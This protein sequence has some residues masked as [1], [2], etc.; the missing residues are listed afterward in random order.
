MSEILSVDGLHVRYGHVHAV[1]D[2]SF[3]VQ[4]GGLMT[5]VGANGAGKTSILNAIAGLVRPAGGSITFKGVDV[6]RKPAHKMVADGLVQV[7]E[8]REVLESLSVAENL[9]LGAWHRRSSSTD[10]IERMYE[11][12]PV[13]AQRR[14]L[15]AGSLSGGEQQ[16][17]AI[18]RALVAEP[19]LL[20]MDEPSM[21]LAPRIVDEVFE[22][23]ASIQHSGT[24]VVLVEQNARRALATADYG[25]VLEI[26]EVV[27]EGPADD[28]LVDERVI[29]AYLGIE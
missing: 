11:R 5:I 10:N 13:L 15:Q 8:G 14:G 6:T 23:I 25:Y 21:G 19:E 26:G 20:L 16:M 9:A 4:A 22:V 18:A 24:T 12:F 17:L 29:E 3:A 7:P 2:V 1:R 28:L 27:H